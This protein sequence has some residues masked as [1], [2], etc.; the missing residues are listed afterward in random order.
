M[1]FESNRKFDSIYSPNL[2]NVLYVVKDAAMDVAACGVVAVNAEAVVAAVAVDV[3]VGVVMT[4][5]HYVAIDFYAAE[6]KS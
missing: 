3:A 1:I 4:E 2:W 6:K 5:P